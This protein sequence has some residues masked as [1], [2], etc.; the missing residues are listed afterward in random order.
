MVAPGLVRLSP[1]GPPVDIVD[2][3]IPPGDI[4]PGLPGEVITTWY[5][6]TRN[7]ARWLSGTGD[8]GVHLYDYLQRTSNVANAIALALTENPTARALLLPARDLT[9][10]RTVGDFAGG[11]GLRS[12]LAFIGVP[13]ATKFVRSGVFTPFFAM[14]TN[15]ENVLWQGVGFELDNPTSFSISIQAYNPS[16]WIV[17][18]C[19]FRCTTA[20]SFNGGNAALAMLGAT[21]T[22]V[23]NSSFLR[24]QC[25]FGGLGYGARSCIFMG[26]VGDFVDDFLVSCV[27]GPPLATHLEIKDICIAGN[28]LR[29]ISGSGGIF[30]GSDG[31][32]DPADVVQGINI[33]GNTFV[34]GIEG[35]ELAGARIYIDFVAGLATQN[36]NIK[37][38]IIA[39]D[40]NSVV[41]Q[42]GILLASAAG[43]TQF[44]D[45]NI[46][47]NNV[48]SLGVNGVQGI[49][50]DPAFVDG[51]Q[52][53]NNIL[54]GNRGILANNC[55]SR[56]QIQG[57]QVFGATASALIVG[58]NGQN[59]SGME[60][61]DNYLESTTAFQNALRLQGFTVGQTIAARIYR[62]VLRATLANGPSYTPNGGTG[63]FRFVDNELVAGS[64]GADA[65]FQTAVTF[66][67]D[68]E[69]YP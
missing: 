27:C 21:N 52:V 13:G 16:N 62:N 48:G 34:G 11:D 65:A 39:D 42:I 55:R 17:D 6:G 26:N 31:G 7:V 5:D 50:I 32:S 66:A 57:N 69:N 15:S 40:T 35:P 49:Y 1:S 54:R 43:A 67:R 64:G 2:P 38:N 9:L 30:V 56:S 41:S 45:V 59:I 53:K 33:L 12:Q 22:R 24:S 63:N 18:K 25:G 29:G 47:G 8:A 3:P 23:T 4:L 68:N 28:T 10:D 51:I 37:D 58:A 44:R 36:I 14:P 20:S 19:A 61:Y 46:S 60:I